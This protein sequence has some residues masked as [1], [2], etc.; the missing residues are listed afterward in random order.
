MSHRHCPDT[1]RLR[2]EHGFSLPELMISMT[3]GLLILFAMLTVFDTFNTGVDANSRAT[4]AE[5][6]GRR[7]VAQMVRILRDA[8]APA[9]TTGNSTATLIRATDNDVV[10]R[11]TSWPGESATGSATN[12]ERL[13]LDTTTKT[14]WFDGR[15][16]TASGPD[17][18]GVACPSVAS[19]WTHFALATKVANTTDL[20]LFRIGTSAVRSIG[21]QLRT[22]SSTTRRTTALKLA[23]GGTMR[24]SLPPTVTPGD[25][26][27]D[28]AADGATGARKP[29]VSLNSDPG[30]SGLK[31]GTTVSGA[32]TAGAGKVLLAAGTTGPVQL[33]VTNALGLQTLLFKDI[34]C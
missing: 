12:I 24:G 33:V 29:L 15:R 27:V 1:T 22:D 26:T 25:L 31:L 2:A 5:D 8:G 34:P 28:C 19:G 17:D 9:P 13:C 16:S 4:D 30:L 20:P 14:V 7:N 11:S 32:V 18:P 10:L 23:S 21:I 3:I 6:N